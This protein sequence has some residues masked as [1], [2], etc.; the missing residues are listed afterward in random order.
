MLRQSSIIDHIITI[1]IIIV[2]ATSILFSISVPNTKQPRAFIMCYI[3]RSICSIVLLACLIRTA[4]GLT[5]PSEGQLSR[6]NALQGFL[7]AAAGIASSN[8]LVAPANAEEE[9]IDVY[10][11]CG[12]SFFDSYV[13]YL[14]VVMKLVCKLISF[15]FHHLSPSRL[16]LACP[17]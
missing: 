10:F 11:G 5:L 1:I 4:N 6:R 15:H 9:L 13:V 3:R 12:K 8:Q 2:L 16:F 14:S 17:A 7:V